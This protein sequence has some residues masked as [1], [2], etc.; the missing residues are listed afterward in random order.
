MPPFVSRKRVS[1]EDPPAPKRHNA[2]PAVAAVL[3]DDTDSSSTDSSLS[4]VP[5]DLQDTPNPGSTNDSAEDSS[6]SESEEVD[7][8]DAF[9]SGTGTASAS[10]GGA[11][12]PLTPSILAPVHQHQDL[13]LTLDKNEVHL[14]DIVEGK[15]A[16]SKIERQIRITTHCLHVRFLLYHNALRN[17]WAN[18]PKLHEI[19]RRKLPPAL[20]QEVKKWRVSSGLELPDQK[21]PEKKPTRKGKGKGKGRQHQESRPSERD[22]TEGSERLEAGQPDLSRGDPIIPLLKVLAAY[23]KKQFTIT[24]P[25]LRKQGYRPMAQLE[26]QIASLRNDAHDPAIHGERIADL[27]EFRQAAERMQ[28]SRDLGAQLFTALLRALGI[29]ARLVASLQPLG[30]GWTKAETYTPKQQSTKPADTEPATDASTAAAD[31]DE[32]M[33]LESDSSSDAATE[34]PSRSNSKNLR[35]YDKD[36]P[37]PI[38]WTE[39]ASPIT[40]EIIPVD[41]LVLPNAVATTPEL[42]AAFEPRGAKAEK[43]KQVISYVIAYSSDKTAKDVTTRYLRRRTW[44]GKTKGFRIPVEKITIPTQHKSKRSSRPAAPTTI[45]YDWARVVLRVYERSPK[46]ETAIDALENSTTLLPNQPER[47]NATATGETPDTLQ[48]LRASPD[49]VLERFLRREEALKPGAQPV[50]TFTAGKGP[51]AKTELVYR[52]ADVVRCQSAE[53]WHKEGRQIMA[54]QTPLK[55]VPIRAVTLLRKREVDEYER[56]TGQKPKQGLYAKYQTEYIIPPPIVDGVIPKN[57][58]GNIDCFVP[59]M[60]PRG[61]CHVPWPGTVRICKKLGIDYAEAV[62]G[63]EFGS[64]MAVPV[65]QG[66]VVAAENEELVKD[67]WRV[68]EAEKR[69]KEARKAEARILQTWRKF[70]FGLR[71]AQRVREEYGG[72]DGE[73]GEGDREREERNPF[74]RQVVGQVAE[75]AGGTPGVEAGAGEGNGDGGGFLL[76]G[77]DE[78]DRG[79]GFLLPGEDSESNR[80]GGFLLPGEDDSSDRGGGFLLPDQEDANND[81][82]DDDDND[83]EKLIIVHQ[84]RQ[85]ATPP[86]AVAA[87]TG[88]D[89]DDDNTPA[90]APSDSDEEM[91]GAGAGS[92]AG[93]G[94]SQA[95]AIS[96]SSSSSDKELSPPPDEIPDSEDDEEKFVAE[97]KPPTTRRRTRGGGRGRGR[98]RGRARGK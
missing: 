50:R 2:T 42:Q 3:D 30:F 61:A 94:K 59:S 88:D 24:A 33:G 19:L 45:T 87:D 10:A 51:K 80:G 26:A 79:G 92:G 49:V 38:Y 85:R 60:V 6:S 39:A 58:Y 22:W 41:A 62:T 21:P 84:R 40:H 35:G 69:R 16:P 17:A 55:H 28:G 66:V 4:D 98:G 73:A 81:E 72:G 12:T 8:E 32:V 14:A 18:D 57:D 7:W 20:H 53:S 29:E 91:T 83:N 37:F 97:Y 11:A 76:P 67:A 36:L 23:W 54:G 75:S 9:E 68:E 43:A 46:H 13:E 48:S 5:D 52:R 86:L 47:K 34:P 27:D 95:D 78:E 90:T 15:K 71:I 77:E 56:E 96:L 31:T 70:L 65:I 1:D 82:D 44:P 25:G 74:T 64:K 93:S 63:F 89:D